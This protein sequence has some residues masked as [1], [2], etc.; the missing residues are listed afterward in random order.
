MELRHLRYFVAIA[1]ERSFTRAAAKLRLSHAPAAAVFASAPHEPIT[2]CAGSG[3][4]IVCC[5][6]PYL[7]KP[8]ST[9]GLGDTFTAGTM[10]VHAAKQPA[11]LATLPGLL[12]RPS[13][14]K[15]IGGPSSALSAANQIRS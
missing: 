1:E 7:S 11:V 10:L 12:A 4:R 13:A 3:W 6:A 14:A 15:N 8:A 9:I 2:A 5:A